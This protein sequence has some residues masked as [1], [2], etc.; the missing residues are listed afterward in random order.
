MLLASMYAIASFSQLFVGKMIDRFPLKRLFLIILLAQA[1]VLFLAAHATG[2]LLYVLLT[3]AMALIFGAIPF[4]DAM[5]ARY[6]DDRLRS[7]VSGV[8]LTVSFGISSMAVWLLGP[9]VKAA[10]FS[11]LLLAMAVI[12]LMTL[13]AVFMLPDEHSSTEPVGAKPA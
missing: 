13:A 5:I 4:T 3:L 2:W 9:V 1:P 7:R 6:I 12:A 11:S 8:R 10:G